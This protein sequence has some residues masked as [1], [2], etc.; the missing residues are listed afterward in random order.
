MLYSSTERGE[1]GL[2][3]LKDSLICNIPLIGI[4]LFSSIGTLIK[5]SGLGRST[6]ISND[7]KCQRRLFIERGGVCQRTSR[8]ALLRKPQG[9][10]NLLEKFWDNTLRR[11]VGLMS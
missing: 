8:A 3:L 1:A 9:T 6:G 4:A 2:Q 7:V 10:R 5:A 11:M